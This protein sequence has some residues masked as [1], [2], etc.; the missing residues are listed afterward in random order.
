MIQIWL[1]KYLFSYLS[2]FKIIANYNYYRRGPVLLKS[3]EQY[4]YI[5]SHKQSSGK[6]SNAK[7]ITPIHATERLKI[8]L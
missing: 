6:L 2:A 8:V 1:L 3:I 5:R 4:T 7:G